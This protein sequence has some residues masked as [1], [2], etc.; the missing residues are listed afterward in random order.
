[1]DDAESLQEALDGPEEI[2]AL[3]NDA[4]I[5]LTGIEMLDL[6]SKT[7][8]SYRGWD[9]QEGALLY[10]DSAGYFGDRPYT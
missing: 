1:M 7:L 3:E 2:I 6:E 10:T 9:G 5:D 8:V 4:E